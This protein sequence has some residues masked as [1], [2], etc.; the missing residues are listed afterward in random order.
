MRI[1]LAVTAVVTALQM[2][3]ARAGE[4]WRIDAGPGVVVAPQY[5]GSRGELALPVP[6]VDIGYRNCLFLNSEHGI[7]AYALNREDLQI[8]SSVWFRRGRFHD[9]SSRIAELGDIDNAVQAQIFARYRLGSFELGT[10]FARDFG[11]SSG[12]TIDTSALWRLQLSPQFQMT[13]G[14]RATYGNDRTMQSWFGVTAA[15]A[16]ASGLSEYSPGSGFASAGPTASLNYALSA[17]W[18]LIARLT[19]SILTS[20]ASAS[21]IVQRDASPTIAVGAV[22]RFVP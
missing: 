18:T 7:G 17:N 22:Y 2:R 16:R 5:P 11:G 9:E 10:T 12:L 4:D 1:A 8:G 13:V 6:M 15:Q 19:E 3:P 21:P 14:G 20:K